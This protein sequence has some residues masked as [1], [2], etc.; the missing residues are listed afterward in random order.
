MNIL[1]ISPHYMPAIEFGGPLR[2]AHGLSLALTRC[3]AEVRV[4]TT[5]LKNSHEDLAVAL[6]CPVLQDGI[7]VYYA[8]TRTSRYWGFSP[9]LYRRTK[10]LVAWADL[11]LVHFH[12]QFANWAGAYL[13]RR[14]N[15]PYVIFAHGSF[16][17]WGIARKSRW[18]KLAYLHTLERSNLA[19]P[20]FIAY[21]AH[22]ERQASLFAERG[23][24]LPSGIDPQEL[25]HAPVRGS[26]RMR[27]P[28][29]AGRICILYLGRLNPAQK[30]LDMLLPAFARLCQQRQDV[31]LILAGPDERGGE[32]EVRAQV[33]A[34]G[35]TAHVTLT[36][37]VDGVE[38]LALLRDSD[39]YALVSPSEGLSIALLEA[40]YMGLPVV[41]TNRVG[42]ANA[43]QQ[44]QAGL[45]VERDVAQI[46]DAL[47]T[48][49]EQ[50][51]RRRNMGA[52]AHQL[53]AQ[54]YTWDAIA[55]QLLTTLAERMPQ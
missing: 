32:A 49:V 11:V 22:E 52:N 47:R 50:T 38:K 6:D 12:Y 33:A 36:G 54:H 9:Q 37:M 40:L 24:V 3:G 31:H 42:L 30:G 39:L 21:N 48:L 43:I 35:L 7:A 1:Q 25:A 34:L 29:A 46:T 16:N 4:C 10:E 44:A 14:C 45:V 51:E 55:Q 13:A 2:V 20:L 5:N 28:E 53:V 8:P 26:W 15:K 18:K 17:Q 19:A 27:Y 41:V 23:L